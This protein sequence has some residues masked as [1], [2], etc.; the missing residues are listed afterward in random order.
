MTRMSAHMGAQSM[1]GP[2]LWE[3]S[4]QEPCWTVLKRSE[5]PG[6]KFRVST[7][8]MSAACVQGSRSETV[9]AVDLLSPPRIVPP[10]DSDPASEK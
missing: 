4:G 7:Q 2:R 1:G 6:T 3:E 9:L 8:S 10:E 5:T